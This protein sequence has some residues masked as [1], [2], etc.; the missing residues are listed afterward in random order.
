MSHFLWRQNGYNFLILLVLHNLYCPNVWLTFIVK[1]CLKSHLIITF[2]CE[3]SLLFQWHFLFNSQSQDKFPPLLFSPIEPWNFQYFSELLTLYIIVLINR[4]PPLFPEGF[5]YC[6][7]VKYSV[8]LILSCLR[9][10]CSHDLQANL[11][12]LVCIHTY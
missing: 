12:C 3:M 8:F 2:Y 6:N 4:L 1:S 11:F 9:L 10:L 7:R 5:L